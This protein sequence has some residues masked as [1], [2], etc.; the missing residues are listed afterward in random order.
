[1]K[2]AVN[3]LL[4]KSASPRCCSQGCLAPAPALAPLLARSRRLRRLPQEACQASCLCR[5][6]CADCLCRLSVQ[7]SVQP[8]VPSVQAAAVS[9]ENYG[10]FHVQHFNIKFF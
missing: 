4:K 8:S 1:M 6:V 9:R 5:L 2:M 3:D 10:Q 7:A